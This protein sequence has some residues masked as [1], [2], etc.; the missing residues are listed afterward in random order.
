MRWDY[1]SNDF[2]SDLL[3]VALVVALLFGFHWLLTSPVRKALV[4]RAERAHRH[5]PPLEPGTAIDDV[6]SVRSLDGKGTLALSSLR[7][8]VLFV[9]FWATW[10]APCRREF[11]SIEKLY[12]RYKDKDVLFLCLSQEDPKFLRLYLRKHPLGLPVYTIMQPPYTWNVSALP[13]TFIISKAGKVALSRTGA[14][15]WDQTGTTDLLDSLL[16]KP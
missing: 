6:W 16:T 5:A 11:P 12:R 3:I 1:R 9:N 8:H 13:S 10:C 7:G 15:R 4:D 14:A 2:Y